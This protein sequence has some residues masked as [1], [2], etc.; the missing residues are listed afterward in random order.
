MITIT[1]KPL[2][3]IFSR[4]I[5]S[6]A[7]MTGAVAVFIGTVRNFN[8]G[9]KVRAIEYTAYE[10]M[11]KKDLA[12]IAA[13][14]M[15]KWAVLKVDIAHRTGLLKVGEASIITIVTASHRKDA[16]AA[17]RYIIEE[18]KKTTPIWKKEIVNEIKN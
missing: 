4:K 15:K 13:E 10:K 8:K 16:Y 7:G 17:S 5:T 1:K 14:C 12:R 9:K 18:I 3:F 2:E 11:A 6:G